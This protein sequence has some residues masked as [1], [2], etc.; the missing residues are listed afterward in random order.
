MLSVQVIANLTGSVYHGTRLLTLCPPSLT[1]PPPHLPPPPPPPIPFN[2][3]LL[4]RMGCG[5]VS[6]ALQLR[7]SLPQNEKGNRHDT[8]KLRNRLDL[9]ILYIGFKL[10]ILLITSREITKVR[11]PSPYAK[12]AQY[13]FSSFEWFLKPQNTGRLCQRGLIPADVRG[14]VASRLY[15]VNRAESDSGTEK[16]VNCVSNLVARFGAASSDTLQRVAWSWN[17]SSFCRMTEGGRDGGGFGEMG[18]ESKTESK[19]EGRGGEK[20]ERAKSGSG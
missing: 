20:Q 14:S 16:A 10:S 13:S 11:T 12:I 6:S 18:R 9:P 5:T 7:R 2:T 3:S 19:R 1:F 17:C 8:K 4:C 15:T